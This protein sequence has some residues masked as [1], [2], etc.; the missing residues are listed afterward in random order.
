M[1]SDVVTYPRESLIPVHLARVAGLRDP[2][3]RCRVIDIVEVGALGFVDGEDGFW[4]CRL[5]YRA[6]DRYLL[7]CCCV[8]VLLGLFGGGVTCF[9]FAFVGFSVGHDVFW[10]WK[11]GLC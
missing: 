1:L 6:V 10:G 5:C 2:A 11:G 9:G 8:G 7:G 3:E 4:A